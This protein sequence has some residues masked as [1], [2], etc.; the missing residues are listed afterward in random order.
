MAGENLSGEAGLV[1]LDLNL[2]DALNNFGASTSSAS[3]T[4]SVGL[5][6]GDINIASGKS[7]AGNLGTAKSLG[8]A[9]FALGGFLLFQLL[10]KRGK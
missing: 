2:N 7:T 5:T 4:S 6:F 9:M 1:P 3:S 10:S 8:L